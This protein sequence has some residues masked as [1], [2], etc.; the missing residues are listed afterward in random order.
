MKSRV[1]SR[2]RISVLL[3]FCALLAVGL[4]ALAGG[5]ATALA[6]LP[7]W[8][9][10]AQ[11]LRLGQA[12]DTAAE[13]AMT[14]QEEVPTIVDFGGAPNAPVAG[15]DQWLARQNGDMQAASLDA[16]P[17]TG[18]K[19]VVVLRVYFND[20]ANASLLTQADVQA[21]FD[22]LDKLWRNTSYNKISIVH[23][24]S[25]LYQL[26]SNR[27]AYIDDGDGWTDTNGNNKYDPGV[28]NSDGDGDGVEGTPCDVTSGG[29]LS[30][31]G[32]YQKVLD[33]AVANAPNTVDFS[34][35]DAVFV[36]MAETGN[37][38][39]RGQANKCTLPIG[40]NGANRTV[41]CAIFS[42]NPTEGATARWGRWAHEMGHA[43]QAAGP[44]HPSNYNNA[45]EL[46]DASYPGQTGV[47]EKLDNMGF[48][49]WMPAAKYVE[50]SPTSKGDQIC[51]LAEEY[52]PTSKPA[53]PQA[54]KASITGSLYYMISV[55]R[56]VL[57]DDVRPIPDE[58]V[59]IER[60]SEGADQWVT[61][62]GVGGNRNVLWKNGTYSNAGDGIFIDISKK[63]DDDNYC[64][65]V[66]YTDNS[67]QPDV[68][69]APWTSAPGNT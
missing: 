45:F 65:T 56:A 3:V 10:V 8:E 39:H 35:A 12:G 36:L 23:R 19:T 53:V 1:D 40:T 69:I 13:P 42:E 14:P 44:A 30:C 55:R 16:T 63:L 47:F 17:I 18:P 57:G 58:G 59:L 28:D 60:V 33:D 25:E 9:P 4:T 2:K 48:P 22:D 51:L 32:K 26:P 64:V 50:I 67:N 49:G 6:S 66:R 20:Y 11:A 68:M 41:G 38:F 62:Q 21:R 37:Q 5:G 29:D 61:V 52:D 27:S 15:L 54:I 24:V 34:S 46:M 43:F 31:D 7:Q